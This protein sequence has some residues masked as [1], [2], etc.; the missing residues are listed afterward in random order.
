M[1][2]PSRHF[3]SIYEITPGFLAEEGV[4]A[5][6]LDI[7]NT[8]VT[9]GTEKPTE[10]VIEWINKMRGGGI[11]ITIASNNGRDR[12]EKF[13]EGLDVFFTYKSGKPLTKCV[14]L[15]SKKFGIPKKSVGVVGDQIFTDVLC[16]SFSG[17]KAYLV[18]PLNSPE[19]PFIRFK[20]VL[21]KP[22][23]SSYKKRHPEQFKEAGK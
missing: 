3:N 11:G 8:L 17:A 16:A 18:T 21:E 9:Y 23:I 10:P 1:F 6:V 14:T 2:Y 13:C 15:S 20:R 5:L 12:V 4:G 19:N 22:I 7:D